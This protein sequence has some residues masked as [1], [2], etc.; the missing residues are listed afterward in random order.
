MSYSLIFDKFFQ[1][2]DDLDD[3]HYMGMKIHSLANMTM[4]YMES[5]S[6]KPLVD[7]ITGT[8]GWIIGIIDHNKDK[9]IF[10]RDLEEKFGITRS[11]VSKVVNLMVQKGLLERSSVDYDARLKKLSLTDKS[12]ELIEY[13]HEDN[14]KMDAVLL[15]GFSENEKAALSDYIQRMKNNLKISFEE[16]GVDGGCVFKMGEEE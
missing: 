7:S 13:M 8:N 5:N 2:V 1:G 15:R 4:R 12:R 9:E 11:T 6:H 16:T 3:K 14:R 10:Q